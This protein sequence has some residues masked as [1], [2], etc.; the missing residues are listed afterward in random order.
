M[1]GERT[2]EEIKVALG[3]AFPSEDEPHADG[4]SVLYTATILA[5]KF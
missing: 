4:L 2:A 3:S 1:L 5:L